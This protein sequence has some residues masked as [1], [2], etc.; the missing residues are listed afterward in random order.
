MSGTHITDVL[1]TKAGDAILV[2]HEDGTYTSY[3]EDA[4]ADVGALTVIGL[5]F[6]LNDLE[7]H[8][9]LLRRTRNKVDDLREE[10]REAAAERGGEIISADLDFFDPTDKQKVDENA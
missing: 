6:L 5:G 10:H 7:W 2:V 1:K 9:K 8:R 4:P 3:L